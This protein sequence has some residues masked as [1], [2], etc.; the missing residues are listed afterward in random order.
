[1]NDAEILDWLEKNYT[2][3]REEGLVADGKQFTLEY[4]GTRGEHKEFRGPSLRDC[5]R[6]L[7]GRM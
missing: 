1:M 2:V 6:G 4:I 7:L 3:F 5:V